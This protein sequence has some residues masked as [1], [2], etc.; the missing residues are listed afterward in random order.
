MEAL[1]SGFF[2]ALFATLLSVL[3]LYVAKEQTIRS[4]VFLEAVSY[5]DNIY[6]KLLDLNYT[7]DAEFR[8]KGREFQAEEYDASSRELRI[9]LLSGKVPAKIVLVYGEGEAIGTYNTLK[10][11]LLEVSRTL[12]GATRSGWVQEGPKIA[13]LFAND[14]DPLREK[15]ER[16][17]LREARFWS[18]IK[19]IVKR[20]SLLDIHMKKEL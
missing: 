20:E 8:D 17:L 11:F 10:G 19:G 7:K 3:Y 4:E 14:I 15:F 1:L 16:L 12:W 13:N 5:I 18:V 2:G 9:L 6:I